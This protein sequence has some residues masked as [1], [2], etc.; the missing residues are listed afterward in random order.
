VGASVVAIMECAYT[1]AII[2]LSV[3]FLGESPTWVFAAGATLVVGGVFIAARN[4]GNVGTSSDPAS[5]RR[6]VTLGISAIALMA[7]GIVVAKPALDRGDLVEVTLVRLLA[8]VVGQLIWITARPNTLQI[9]RVLRPSRSW[10]TM[11]PAA[12][13]GTYVAMLLWLGG[14]KYT[15]MSTASTL[16][17]LATVFTLVLAWLVLGERLTPRKL[18]G[19]F[20][21]LGGALIILTYA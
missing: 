12:I 14:I 4:P 6:G 16:N 17:Q 2:L 15:S 21:S 9:L 13:L 5:F 7:V 3:L 20:A 18:I 19:G 10:R 8:G 11:A 1:P